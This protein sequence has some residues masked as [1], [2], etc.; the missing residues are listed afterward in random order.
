[1]NYESLK[2]D[3]QL[4]FAL[5]ACAKEVTRIYKPFL[6]KFGITYTQYI[7]L[8]ALWEE[9][10][11]TVKELGK[12]LHLDSG[13]LTPLL[14]KLE[15]MEILKRIRD[16]EDE[17]NVYVKLSEKGMKMKDEALEIPGKVFCSTGMSMEEALD[18]REKLKL[19]LNNLQ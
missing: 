9:D 17:R 10:N 5:Y 19:L 11:I 12:K 7:T 15:N 3:N 1:M 2:L 18:L 8:L 6:D 16:T 14:K 13:T 4:C